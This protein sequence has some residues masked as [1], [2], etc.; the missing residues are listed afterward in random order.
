ML[1]LE[2]D[3][4]AARGGWLEAALAP[5]YD[6]RVAMSGTSLKRTCVAHEGEGQ[7][8]C[9]G[10]FRMDIPSVQF[11]INGNAAYR[12]GP[13][14]TALLEGARAN[15]SSWSF[16]VAAWHAANAQQMGSSLM[17]NDRLYNVHHPVAG[18]MRLLSAML[19]GR[20]ALAH[21]PRRFRIP[22]LDVRTWCAECAQFGDRECLDRAPL[23]TMCA[24]LS[25]A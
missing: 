25:P 11:H 5:M 1:Q 18:D 4:C 24:T 16:D 17:D 12:V 22:A 19:P 3:C 20:A 21:V 9:F 7:R 2:S 14:L 10:A 6:D 8:G 23:A 13:R 15:F